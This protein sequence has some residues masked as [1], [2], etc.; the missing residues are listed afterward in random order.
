LGLRDFYRSQACEEA[1]GEAHTRWMQTQ[2]HYYLW[3]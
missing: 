2:P 1:V 3:A